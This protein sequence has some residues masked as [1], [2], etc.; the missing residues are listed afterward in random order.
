MGCEGDPN[1]SQGI[2]QRS[3]CCYFYLLYRSLPYKFSLSSPSPPQHHI[4]V[5]SALRNVKEED[6][7]PNWKNG[8]VK[9]PC[10]PVPEGS[11]DGCTIQ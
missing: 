10:G 9:K 3:L 11:N 8:G 7:C 2:L 1:P 5:E 4:S 6:R